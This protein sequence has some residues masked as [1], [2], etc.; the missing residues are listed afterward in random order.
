MPETITEE[1]PL[2]VLE[3]VD[4]IVSYLWN[5]EQRDY[6]EEGK[7]EG[8]VFEHLERINTWLTM[9]TPPEKKVVP[10]PREES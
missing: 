3:S 5:D 9:K 4:S 2:D 10:Y 7:P 8:H 1:V 6:E